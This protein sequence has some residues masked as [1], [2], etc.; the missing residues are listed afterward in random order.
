FKKKQ[1]N[2][3]LLHTRLTMESLSKKWV[4]TLGL[5]NAELKRQINEVYRKPRFKFLPSQTYQDHNKISTCHRYINKLQACQF[6]ELLRKLA[7]GL[8]EL[9]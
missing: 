1:N 7:N 2:K 3:N 9:V 4:S 5:Q 8:L 6:V